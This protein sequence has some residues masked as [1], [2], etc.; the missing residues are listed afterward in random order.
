MLLDYSFLKHYVSKDVCQFKYS[1]KMLKLE[2]LI[3]WKINNHQ[4]FS[5]RV[6]MNELS[7]DNGLINVLQHIFDPNKLTK[8]GIFFHLLGKFW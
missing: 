1:S 3:L 5:I 4:K 6:T 2:N 7:T 8:R